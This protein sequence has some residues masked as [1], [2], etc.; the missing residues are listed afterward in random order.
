MRGPGPTG[1]WL[2]TGLL[3][4]QRDVLLY[5]FK[6]K[7]NFNSH[8]QLRLL[9]QKQL[10]VNGI[11]FKLLFPAGTFSIR[12]TEEQ[13]PHEKHPTL[14]PCSWP[15]HRKKH[16]GCL[17]SSEIRFASKFLFKDFFPKPNQGV[18]VKFNLIICMLTQR[19][20]MATEHRTEA[21][22]I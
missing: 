5:I 7:A 11:P 1:P 20:L 18:S 22:T 6:H 4:K 10:L 8:F 14:C 12:K 3:L 21:L 9:S 13:Q 15:S 16:R 19:E 17:F 2:A